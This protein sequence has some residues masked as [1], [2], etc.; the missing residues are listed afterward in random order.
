MT[1]R[2]EVNHRG[3]KL[4]M[5]VPCIGGRCPEQMQLEGFREGDDS[6][7]MYRCKRKHGYVS[8]TGE[9]YTGNCWYHDTPYPANDYA[10]WHRDPDSKPK[11]TD[12]RK[13]E[14]WVGT[15]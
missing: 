9:E 10:Y 2:V 12:L 8:G 7:L 5:F 6:K 13:E 14:D 4:P 11:H 1:G 3:A 15:I